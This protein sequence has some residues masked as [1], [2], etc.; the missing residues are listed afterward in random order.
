MTPQTAWNNQ[1]NITQD[2][3]DTL[4]DLS[5]NYLLSNFI[6][7]QIAIAVVYLSFHRSITTPPSEG[8]QPVGLC[9]MAKLPI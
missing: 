1:N 4:F 3:L 5:L 7:E 9:V 2:S 8:G 6:A